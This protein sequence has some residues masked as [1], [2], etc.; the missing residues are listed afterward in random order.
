MNKSL[1][2]EHSKVVRSG[3]TAIFVK[4]FQPQFVRTPNISKIELLFEFLFSFSYISVDVLLAS[5]NSSPSFRI[6]TLLS[7]VQ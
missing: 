2:N 3:I 7:F 6:K 1:F 4:I 5:L